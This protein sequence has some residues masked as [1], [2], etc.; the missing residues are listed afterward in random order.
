MR[1]NSGWKVV[2]L[3][4]TFRLSR[5][6]R[7]IR[8]EYLSN[9]THPFFDLCVQWACEYCILTFI[10]DVTCFSKDSLLLHIL[11]PP[12][13]RIELYK[14]VVSPFWPLALLW[15]NTL[16]STNVRPFSGSKKYLKPAN[17][18]I[19]LHSRQA[20]Y[21]GNEVTSSATH[22]HGY[23]PCNNPCG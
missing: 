3:Q 9:R 8:G 15:Q 14:V 11:K 18:D 22:C 23:H 2:S 20:T 13:L 6:I 10:F 21:T 4:W 17:A 1:G 12:N 16:S 19:H 7:C 5:H